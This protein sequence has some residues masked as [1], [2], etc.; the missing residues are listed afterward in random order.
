MTLPQP[1]S[2]VFLCEIRN[3]DMSSARQNFW[4]SLTQSGLPTKS[5]RSLELSHDPPRKGRTTGTTPTYRICSG[6]IVKGR[7][8][9]SLTVSD[10]ETFKLILAK[11]VNPHVNHDV[12]KD[13]RKN[14]LKHCLHTRTAR[15]GKTHPVER[16]HIV[17]RTLQFPGLVGHAGFVQQ[18]HSNGYKPGLERSGK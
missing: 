3:R 4:V 5:V 10:S 8:C 1:P 16:K 9:A 2:R 17:T 11:T 12:E 18:C 7:L 15:K 14:V 13:V 6:K